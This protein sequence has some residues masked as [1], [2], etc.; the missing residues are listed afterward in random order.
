MDPRGGGHPDPEI[1]RGAR[2]Q[3]FFRPFGPQLGPQIKAGEGRGEEGRGGGGD[4]SAIST[5]ERSSASPIPKVE[6]HLSD[7]C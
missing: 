4:F 1:R 2:S 7:R 6:S 5:T 3:I